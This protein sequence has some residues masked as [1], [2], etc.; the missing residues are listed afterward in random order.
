MSTKSSEIYYEGTILTSSYP[1][2]VIVKHDDIAMEVTGKILCV[3]LSK[4][5]KLVYKSPRISS[6]H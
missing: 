1:T 2:I 6:A 5:A 3:T 4:E